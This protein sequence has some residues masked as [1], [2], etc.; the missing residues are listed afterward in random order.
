MGGGGKQ[1]NSQKTNPRKFLAKPQKFTVEILLN[2]AAGL[3][4]QA[5]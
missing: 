4:G 5:I 1:K 3:L 2:A